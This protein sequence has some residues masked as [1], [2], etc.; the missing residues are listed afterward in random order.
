[1]KKNLSLTLARK[2]NKKRMIPKRTKRIQPGL[3]TQWLLYSPS[4]F[5]DSSSAWCIFSGI[6][7]QKGSKAEREREVNCYLEEQERKRE[8]GQRS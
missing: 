1:M 4:P 7:L 8:N 6:F 5:N 2:K 3:I